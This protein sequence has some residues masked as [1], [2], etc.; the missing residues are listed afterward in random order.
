MRILII[1][2]FYDP[3]PAAGQRVAEAASA[4]AARGHT[5]RVLARKSGGAQSRREGRAVAV[6]RLGGPAGSASGLAGK[7]IATAWFQMSAFLRAL[8]S[9]EPLDV[10]LT[11][12][13]PP[14]CH[15]AGVIV[16]RLRGVA[17]VFWCADVHPD[18]LIAMGA[19]SA[20]SLRARLLS[21]ANRWALRRCD[22]II[23]VGRCMRELLISRGAAPERIQ[24]VPMWHRDALAEL[25]DPD[26]VRALQAELR[27][28]GRFVV[29]YSGN[30][31]RMH[32]FE[33]ILAAAERLH[34]DARFVFLFSGAGSALEQVRQQ[35][36][37]R[38]REQI[39]IHPLFPEEML[40]E[41][42]ALASV[43]VITLRPSAAGVSV[44]GKVYGAMAAGRPV[45]FIGPAESEVAM[46]IREEGCGFVI[47]A[48]D[49]ATLV[50]VLRQ[51]RA[52]PAAAETLG[53]RGRDAFRNR[54]S[55]SHRCAQ[56]SQAIERTVWR[57]DAGAQR[58]REV[59]ASGIAGPIAPGEEQHADEENPVY[60]WHASGSHQA[61]PAHP[62]AKR[63]F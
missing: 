42:L 44:P 28:R 17:H 56:F 25:P 54:Y 12:S 19:L 33:T 8:I 13:T 16:S 20:H 53:N 29:M 49:A 40:P 50:D 27:L 23:A 21:A 45:I 62:L 24:T 48:G 59:A 10:L 26:R 3:D 15:V 55:Q 61:L 6:R 9:R 7:M 51:L 22:A 39:R 36:A 14:M 32:D 1:S 34:D 37:R 58:V 57:K 47:A 35:A 2:E 31:G 52:D 30:L 63:F 4:L 11:V 38:G 41:V 46:T 43:H 5:V 60:S 18:S